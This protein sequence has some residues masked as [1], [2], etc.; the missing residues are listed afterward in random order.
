MISYHI[1]LLLTSNAL[2]SLEKSIK[3]QQQAAAKAKAEAEGGA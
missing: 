3:K 1:Q 2:R